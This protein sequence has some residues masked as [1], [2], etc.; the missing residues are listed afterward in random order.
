VLNFDE[1]TKTLQSLDKPTQKPAVLV[2]DEIVVSCSS[3]PVTQSGVSS[4]LT[5]E[6]QCC[7]FAITN[8]ETKLSSFIT[9]CGK[10]VSSL[11]T[12]KGKIACLRLLPTM[13]QRRVRPLPMKKQRCVFVYH[14]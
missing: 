3:S 9:I 1:N 13:E 14:Q 11:I 12:N 2:T 4:L 5:E 7:V 6:E 8:E 10:R